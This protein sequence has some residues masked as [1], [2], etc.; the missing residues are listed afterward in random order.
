MTWMVFC[1]TMTHDTIRV[2][3]ATPGSTVYDGNEGQDP[4]QRAVSRSIVTA[5][6]AGSR[7]E[8]AALAEVHAAGPRD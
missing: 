7:P 2:A 4:C 8:L 3:L 5:G 1:V 6:C